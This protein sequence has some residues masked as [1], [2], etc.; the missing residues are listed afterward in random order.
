MYRIIDFAHKV[1]KD[2]L[3]ETDNAVDATCGNGFD[4]FFLA[5]HLSKGKVFAFDIQEV[6][7]K[8]TKTLISQAKLDNVYFFQTNHIN[9]P[10]IITD[11]FQ[12]VIFNLGYLPRGD[13]SITTKA[14]STITSI[15]HLLEYA[16][17]NPNLLIIL[18]IY[19]GHDEG[20][21]ESEQ[22]LEFVKQLNNK[23]Y[24]VTKFENF[25]RS[26]SPYVITIKKV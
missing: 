14:I 25:N 11:P 5:K 15:K 1:L 13:K 21:L 23:D 17:E 16:F 20:K 7:I 8:N 18:V 24:L 6:A 26:T 4:T 9:I 12:A 10:S 3:K 22:L 2:H 19:T